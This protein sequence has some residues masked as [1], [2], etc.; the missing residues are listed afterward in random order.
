MRGKL[1]VLT[2]GRH[3]AGVECSD[4]VSKSHMGGCVLSLLT[5]PVLDWRESRFGPTCHRDPCR[6]GEFDLRF[7]NAR[8]DTYT[9][10]Q[11]STSAFLLHV[12]RWVF[13][14]QS[15]YLF[16]LHFCSKY[17]CLETEGISKQINK[18]SNFRIYIF[19]YLLNFFYF[20]FL[21]SEKLTEKDKAHARLICFHAVNLL[22]KKG[23]ITHTSLEKEL[24]LVCLIF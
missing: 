21:F 14:I 7:L 12:R 2:L 10:D 23:V 24:L 13:L 16:S 4:C 6:V 20:C 15:E 22:L 1:S 17:S 3:V 8:A 19:I 5:T 18:R 9:V 11:A